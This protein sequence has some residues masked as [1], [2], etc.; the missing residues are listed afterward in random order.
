MGNSPVKSKRSGKRKKKALDDR[1]RRW[2]FG[3]KE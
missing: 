2:G 3:E 1:R